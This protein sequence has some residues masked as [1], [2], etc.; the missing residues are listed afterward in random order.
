[1]G[2]NESTRLE[3]PGPGHGAVDAV[4]ERPLEAPAVAVLAIALVVGA[5]AVRF[6]GLRRSQALGGRERFLIA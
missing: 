1:M 4:L 3:Q 6:G 2:E 5:A